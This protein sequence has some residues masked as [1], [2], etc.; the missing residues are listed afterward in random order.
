MTAREL[1]NAVKKLN[2]ELYRMSFEDTDKY[3][4]YVEKE[5]KNEFIRIYCADKTL[6]RLSKRNILV[7]FR[8]NLR[9]RFIA[10]HN[11]GTDIKLFDN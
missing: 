8:L 4:E 2:S 9:H 6:E 10:F 1:N 7:M 3:L 5:A 11:F